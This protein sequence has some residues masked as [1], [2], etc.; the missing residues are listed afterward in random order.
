MLIVTGKVFDVYVRKLSTKI[1][2]SLM[3]KRE[4]SYLFCESC[5][6]LAC[7]M[8]SILDVNLNKALRRHARALT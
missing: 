5:Y 8:R 7:I 2:L 3:I 4:Y 1:D 6:K